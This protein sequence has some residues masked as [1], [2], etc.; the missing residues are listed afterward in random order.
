[1]QTASLSLLKSPLHFL[2]LG[3]GS[4][5]SAKAPGTAGSAVAWLLAFAFPSLTNIYFVI[6]ASI[7]GIYICH[8]SAKKMGTHDHPAIVWD[9]FCGQW[10]CLSYV[11]FVVGIPNHNLPSTLYSWIAAFILFRL[12]D[13]TKPWPICWLDK[14]L[15]GG[16]GIML[17]D[18]AAA[19]A[20]ILVL[21]LGFSVL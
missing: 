9:E 15:N 11:V 13:I 21:H 10:L 12:F 17:D 4:G 5:L 16:W 20:T 19:L 3:F 18:I 2:A 1:M 8:W 6:F 7:A 14:T